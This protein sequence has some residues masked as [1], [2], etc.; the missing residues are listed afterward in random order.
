MPVGR[1]FGKPR[2]R[3]RVKPAVLIRIEATVTGATMH[4]RREEIGRH[5]FPMTASRTNESH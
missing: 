1:P 5:P 2:L 4:A 3:V